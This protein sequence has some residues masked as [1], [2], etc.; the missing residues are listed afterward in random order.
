M[1][2]AWNKNS[3]VTRMIVMYSIPLIVFLIIVM[4]L[5]HNAQ[6]RVKDEFILTNQHAFT[7]FVDE[8]E[9]KIGLASDLKDVVTKNIN[10]LEFIDSPNMSSESEFLGYYLD[11]VIPIIKYATAFSE[12]SDYEIKVFLMNEQIP[13]SWPYFFHMRHQQQHE[14]IQSFIADEAATLMWLGVDNAP[15]LPKSQQAD[16]KQYTLVS[17]LYSSTRQLLGLV[18]IMV[19]EQYML[20]SGGEHGQDRTLLLIKQQQDA[21]AVLEDEAAGEQLQQQ[22]QTAEVPQGY[23]MQNE[24]IYF[25]H[26]FPDIDETLVY[27]VALN[28]LNASMS[29]STSYNVLMIVGCFVIF[30]ITCMLMFKLIFMRLNRMIAIMRK[31]I[32]GDLKMRIPDK[33]SDELG[34]LA[35]DMNGLIEMNNELIGNMLM[36]ERLR[37]EAQIQ[38]LQYQINPHF[39]YNTLDVFRMRLIKE[40]MFWIADL[41]ADFGKILR[42]NLS[43]QTHETTLG[44]EL[45][46]IRKYMNLQK[47][48]TT[49]NIELELSIDEK[50]KKYPVIKFLLQPVVENCLKHGKNRDSKQLKIE[51]S[52]EIR[53]QDIFI[54]IKDNGNGI[55]RQKLEQ[56]NEAF[57][58][59][60]LHYRE[61]ASRQG[62]SIGLQNINSR[63]RLYYGEQYHLLIDSEPGQYTCVTIRIPY[64]WEVETHGSHPNSR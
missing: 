19:A 29:K 23:F 9:Q 28:E 50:L 59:P 4:V 53:Q 60:L 54:L 49:H 45:E 40:K 17:K 63:L 57:R 5:N 7:Q 24:F 12:N 58:M 20:P 13:E 15:L 34:Q 30:I 10:L 36:K 47:I 48:S 14:S 11:N 6:Q 26:W 38:A 18:T 62:N 25:Y 39:I 51:I 2:L 16:R 31:V 42:Y 43:E 3:I 64:Q 21:G 56:L 55:A 27:K 1:K 44:E 22:L 8:L 35:Q 33:R 52:S 32:Q 37:K 61:Q 41:L 46:L